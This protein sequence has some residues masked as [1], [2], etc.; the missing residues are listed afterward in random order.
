MLEKLILIIRKLFG[1]NPPVS[2][3]QKKINA[4][5]EYRQQRRTLQR[6]AEDINRAISRFKEMACSAEKE[7]NH[8]NAVRCAKFVKGL[9]GAQQ[10]IADVIQR[11]DMLHC[12]HGYSDILVQFMDSCTAI[13]L[14]MNMNI[15]L[16]K[17]AAGQASLDSGL[18]QLDYLS[19]RIDQTLESIDTGAGVSNKEYDPV[20]EQMLKELLA[21]NAAAV[22]TTDAVFMPERDALMQQEEPLVRRKEFPDEQGEKSPVFDELNKRLIELQ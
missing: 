5:I 9:M 7:G 12:M 15:D 2:P 16:E 14:N 8:E 13:G 4:E 6:N 10:K 3:E 18:Q 21:E 20:A 1:I 17:L 22:E 19:E 11:Y